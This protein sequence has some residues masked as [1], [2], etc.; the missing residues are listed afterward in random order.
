MKLNE[1]IEIA[2]GGPVKKLTNLFQIGRTLIN[3]SLQY[4]GG[5][6]GRKGNGRKA[7]KVDSVQGSQI[8][9]EEYVY[10]PSGR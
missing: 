1:P 6:R 8:H 9:D 10:L 7:R 3:F 4:N 5:G 2:N